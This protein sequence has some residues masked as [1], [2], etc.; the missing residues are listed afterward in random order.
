MS[1]R[2]R[3]A[4]QVVGALVAV[5]ALV[6][7]GS[8]LYFSLTFGAADHTQFTLTADRLPRDRI[9]ENATAAL[10]EREAAVVDEAYRNGSARTV[11]ERV[12][13]DGAYVERNGTYYRVHVEHGPDVTRDRPVLT[14]A[15]VN[16]SGGEVV[17]ASD[18]PPPDERAFRLAWRAWSVRNADRGSG[19]PPVGHV[20]E[21]VPDPADSVFVPDQEVR[22]VRHEN[23]TFRVLVRTEHVSLDSTAYRLDPVAGNESA[24]VDVL[25]RNV[26]G[27]LN[28]SAAQPLDRAVAN[29]SYVSRASEYAAAERPIRPVA[30]AIGVDDPADLLYDR[31]GA[32]VRYVRYEGRYYRVTLS[33]Y[34]TAA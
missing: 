34:T 4:L 11:A 10:S 18:L 15:Q 9:A 27:R 2:V 22:Y 14:I 1:S 8:F 31:D 24:F 33:G 6:V 30:E 5:G 7:A 13:L 17:P 29:G 12:D 32:T 19:D 20:Y 26:T 21:T 3:R 16:E 25:V 28:D 23:R